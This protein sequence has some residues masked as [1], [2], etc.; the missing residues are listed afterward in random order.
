M[1][2]STQYIGLNQ[3]ALNFVKGA[4]LVETFELTE[5]MF[6]E[7]VL[8]SVYHMPPPAGPNDEYILKEVVQDVPWSSGPMIF[9]HLE[10]TLVKKSGQ[11][12]K[13]G[14]YFSWMVDPSIKDE[15]DLETGRY[16]I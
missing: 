8:G 5:G 9:T 10:A 12:I 6:G 2:R 16:Y 3:Y 14:P 15:Y 11:R 7:P 1:S 13:L 4:K